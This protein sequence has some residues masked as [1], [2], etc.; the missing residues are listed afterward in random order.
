[1]GSVTWLVHHWVRVQ[2][3]AR[4]RQIVV[5]EGWACVQEDTMQEVLHESVTKR[6]CIVRTEQYVQNMPH[7][8]HS[9]LCTVCA[10]LL[11]T[12]E[13]VPRMV[14]KAKQ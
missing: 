3:A 12:F 7:V 5:Q 6:I 2:N 13:S 1:M 11:L 10:L 8:P 4:A 9:T 14:G